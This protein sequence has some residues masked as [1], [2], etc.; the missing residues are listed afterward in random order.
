VLPIGDQWV[1][2]VLTYQSLFSM[3]EMLL[4]HA[5]DPGHRTLVIFDEVHHLCTESGW[6]RAAQESFLNDTTTVLSL[7]GTP[8]RTDRNPI[9]FVKSIEGEAQ[10]DVRYTYGEAIIDR[11]CRP[12]QF[13]EGRGTSTFRDSDGNETLVTFD[14]TNLTDSGERARLRAAIEWV[15]PASIADML[16]TDANEHLLTL[17]RTNDPD[18]AGLIVTVDCDH[19]DEVARHVQKHVTGFRPTVACSRL[20]DDNDPNPASAIADFRESS[21]PWI[22]AVNMVSEGVD[23]RRLRVV[24]YLTNRAT[25]MSF[26]QIVGRVVRSDITNREDIGRVYLPADPN[27]LAM[28]RRVIDQAPSLLQPIQIITDQPVRQGSMFGTK[29]RELSSEVVHSDG[30]HGDA[31][32]TSGRNASAELIRRAKAFIESSGLQDSDPTS[33]ALLALEHPTIMESL[34][35]IEL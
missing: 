16:I 32:D 27:L 23:I 17:R 8:F 4:A 9:A 24:V 11:A 13:V 15:E 19:A 6:G 18:A 7:S 12:V 20:H 26:R 28:A 22:V 10:P 30:V 3:P 35:E 31:F 14:D 21:D 29:A 2:A 5:T 25:E 34:N 1:G 33:L